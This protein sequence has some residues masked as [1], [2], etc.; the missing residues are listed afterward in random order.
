V[1]QYIHALYMAIKYCHK[2]D[3]CV[4]FKE[5]CMYRAFDQLRPRRSIGEEFVYG[6]YMEILAFFCLFRKNLVLWTWIVWTSK[7]TWIENNC[8]LRN[9]SQFLCYMRDFNEIKSFSI[10]ID[11]FKWRPQRDNRDLVASCSSV[12]VCS[13]WCFCSVG[14]LIS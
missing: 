2:R 5:L 11:A 10:W 14:G 1:E 7:T 13:A 6:T 9:F 3:P 8:I 12:L 4:F